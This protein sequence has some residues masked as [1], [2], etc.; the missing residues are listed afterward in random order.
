MDRLRDA[1]TALRDITDPHQAPDA[2][3]HGAGSPAP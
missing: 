3:Q 2:A 1:L